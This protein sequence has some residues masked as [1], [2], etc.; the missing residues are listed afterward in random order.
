MHICR[1][2]GFDSPALVVDTKEAQ[3]ICVKCGACHP[4]DWARDPM[5]DF[6]SGTL[7]KSSGV[8]R[9]DRCK[10][11]EKWLAPL[12]LPLFAHDPF[13]PPRKKLATL[14]RGI[15]LIFKRPAVRGARKHFLSYSFVIERMLDIVYTAQQRKGI[16]TGFKPMKS[17]ARQHKHEQMWRQILL[18]GENFDRFRPAGGGRPKDMFAL[19]STS[20][21]T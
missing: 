9:Y 7:E 6:V 2:C 12:H 19:K 8:T 15:E 17:R 5:V 20:R 18:A 3:E 1:D 14:F 10:H 11:L 13:T 4:T 16:T 21:S